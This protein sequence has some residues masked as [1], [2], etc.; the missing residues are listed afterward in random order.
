MEQIIM[1][2][3]NSVLDVLFKSKSEGKILKTDE[4]R[5]QSNI[6]SRIQR[7]SSYNNAV[8][9][10]ILIT[11]QD[12]GRVKRISDSKDRNGREK[13]L[14]AEKSKLLDLADRL[15]KQNEFWMLTKPKPKGSFLNYFRLRR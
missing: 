12:A 9:R 10:G 6:D 8:A 5:R 1:S 14:I 11:L 15:Q 2:I 3:V 7:D 13:A 4:I